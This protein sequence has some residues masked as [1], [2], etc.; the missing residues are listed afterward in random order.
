MDH[1]APRAPSPSAAAPYHAAAQPPP[2]AGPPPPPRSPVSVPSGGE[3]TKVLR[4]LYAQA[5]EVRD[6]NNAL[7]D[8]LKGRDGTKH[9]ALS[10]HLLVSAPD[11]PP[12]S[13]TVVERKTHLGNKLL[14]E[15]L[16]PADYGGIKEC[17]TLIDFRGTGR[18]P[19][20]TGPDP[21]YHT[22]DFNAMVALNKRMTDDMARFLRLEG[23]PSL[24]VDAA[25]NAIP[26]FR[27]YV[28]NYVCIHAMLKLLVAHFE[29][30][31]SHAA[32]L[33]RELQKAVQIIRDAHD[34]YG[35]HV[36]LDC[37]REV[38]RAL[39]HDHISPRCTPVP[40]VPHAHSPAPASPRPALAE[41]AASPTYHHHKT[42]AADLFAQYVLPATAGTGGLA[43]VHHV[44]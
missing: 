17:L 7:I 25:P 1:S 16:R 39:H 12:L 37:H 14:S 26:L 3:D 20:H 30:A 13:L 24:L 9:H 29:D 2:P 21:D 10:L 34:K 22:H 40:H 28:N 32:E 5:V 8:H 11:A 33:E 15:W 42:T 31:T 43:E 18:V 38:Y 41:P 35:F 6:A 36:E 23:G 27:D 4:S 19:S 44:M